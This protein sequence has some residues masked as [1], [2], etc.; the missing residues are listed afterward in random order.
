MPYLRQNKFGS[1]Y[2]IF[3]FSEFKILPGPYGS[4]L[5][6]AAARASHRR[7]VP[8]RRLISQ[9]PHSMKNSAWKTQQLEVEDQPCLKQ[10]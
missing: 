3:E 10:R 6:L 2:F 7:W 1:V 4:P 9:H 8:S 5:P